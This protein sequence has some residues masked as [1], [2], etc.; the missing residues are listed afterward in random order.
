MP[1]SESDV[2]LLEFEQ[3]N[4]RAGGNLCS[5]QEFMSEFDEEH[6]RKFSAAM[7]APSQRIQTR[8]IVRWLE[9]VGVTTNKDTIRRHRTNNCVSCKRAGVTF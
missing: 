4:G 5:V 1:A 6:A 3:L 9:Q 2:D 7:G 8:A